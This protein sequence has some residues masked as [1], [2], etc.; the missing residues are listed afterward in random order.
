MR[1]SALTK[2]AYG[3]SDPFVWVSHQRIKIDGM[4]GPESSPRLVTYTAVPSG[5]TATPHG[6]AKPPIEATTAP[7]A[8]SITDTKSPPLNPVMT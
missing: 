5:L 6:V 7:V 8:V 4:R 3:S 1:I 2:K